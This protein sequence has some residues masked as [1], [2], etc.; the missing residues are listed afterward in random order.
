MNETTSVILSGVGGQGIILASRVLAEAALAS[1][2]QVKV[3]ETHGM[4]QRGGSVVTHV[5]YGP[6]AF[7]PLISWGQADYMIGFE[8]LEAVRCL[9]FLKAGGLWIVND[10]SI[11]PLPVL[12]GKVSYPDLGEGRLRQL[13]PRL[14]LV[15]G[16]DRAFQLG[17]ARVVNMI[18]LGCLAPHLDLSRSRWEEAIDCCVRPEYGELN[19]R[20]FDDGFNEKM[21]I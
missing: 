5:R 9:P 2:N 21:A 6:R 14:H 4:A 13:A 3:S 1:G 18:L 7:S 15:K 16:R 8:K 11:P 20:A 10:Q 12:L 17:N 19:K